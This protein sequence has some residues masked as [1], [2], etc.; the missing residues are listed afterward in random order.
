MDT[1]LRGC[2]SSVSS[3]SRE[4]STKHYYMRFLTR[5]RMYSRPFTLLFGSRQFLSRFAT[6]REPQLLS[7]P[8]NNLCIFEIYLAAPVRYSREH[9]C[10][11]VSA[12]SHTTRGRRIR[13]NRD[14]LGCQL[15][16][17]RRC[18]MDISKLLENAQETR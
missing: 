15:E 4:R 7:I 14:W 5:H 3:W 2:N 17:P 10:G 18:I 1:Y 11:R 16:I 12:R 8:K 6:P 9:R 13:C